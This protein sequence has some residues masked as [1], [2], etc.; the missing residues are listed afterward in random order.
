V[1]KSEYAADLLDKLGIDYAERYATLSNEEQQ[2]VVDMH[3]EYCADWNGDPITVD[4]L[5]SEPPVELQDHYG[6][7]FPH[8][9]PITLVEALERRG[10]EYIHLE[11]SAGFGTVHM[12]IEL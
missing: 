6:E 1:Y 9:D 10:R 3:N 2:E 12:V 5:T 11:E 8:S 7:Y 4:E